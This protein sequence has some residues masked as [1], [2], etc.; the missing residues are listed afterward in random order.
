MHCLLTL[1][2]HDILTKS[3]QNLL[4]PGQNLSSQTRTI[5]ICNHSN[6]LTLKHGSPFS[7]LPSTALLASVKMQWLTSHNECSHNRMA[8]PYLLFYICLTRDLRHFANII[9]VSKYCLLEHQRRCPPWFGR[10]AFQEGWL[11]PSIYI[12]LLFCLHR[13][14]ATMTWLPLVQ[15]QIL[16][17]MRT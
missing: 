11:S 9:P 5:H 3:T 16:L 12:L 7:P 14:T 8:S 2:Y 17:Y 15:Q 4:S 13:F 1:Q 6:H 10:L